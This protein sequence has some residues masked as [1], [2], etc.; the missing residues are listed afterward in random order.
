[1]I[2]SIISAGKISSLSEEA[3]SLHEK[4]C[5]GEKNENKIDYS[6]SEAFYLKEEKKM[7]IFSNKNE[8]STEAILK[9]LKKNDKRFEI[10]YAV[11][12]DMRKKGYILKSALKFGAD[13]RVYDKGVKPS[14]DH[15]CWLVIAL[16]DSEI[17]S[18]IE[19]AGK[20]R[21]AHSTKK[22]LLIAVVDEESC[23]SYYEFNWTRP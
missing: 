16:K 9:N 6:A 22:K 18:W 8:L 21:I 3:F 19:L 17:L 13:F 14:Q 15:A 20:A 7:T 11:Y 10:K 5:F 2:T 4:S 23:I 12:K 1:M